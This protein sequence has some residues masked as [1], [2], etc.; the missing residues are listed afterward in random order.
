M[1]FLSISISIDYYL[2]IRLLGRWGGLVGLGVAISLNDGIDLVIS[3]DIIEFKLY[4]IDGRQL[5]N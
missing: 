2:Y 5:G 4:I 1:L 3:L